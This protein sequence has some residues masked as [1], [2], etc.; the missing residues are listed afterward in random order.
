MLGCRRDVRHTALD[1][2]VL[3]EVYGPYAQTPLWPFMSLAIRTRG[4]PLTLAAAV[5]QR[6]LTIDRDQAVARVRT[7]EQVLAESVAQPDFRMRLLSLFG[8]MALVLATVGVYGVMSY[9]VTER[10][11]EIGVRRFIVGVVDCQ[12]NVLSPGFR[13]GSGQQF[14]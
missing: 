10:M 13:P 7:M 11:R 5:R 14:G 9:T 8:L 2:G 6:V 1:A 4:D 12:V 3:D